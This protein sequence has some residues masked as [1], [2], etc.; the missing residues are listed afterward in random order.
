MVVG[1]D[2]VEALRGIAL[3]LQ[4]FQ[5]LLRDYPRLRHRVR[6][7]QIGVIP[8]SRPDDFRR[9]RAEVQQLVRVEEKERRRECAETRMRMRST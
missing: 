5:R 2:A 7:H 8:D 3:K 4:A 9:T 6:L 1:V